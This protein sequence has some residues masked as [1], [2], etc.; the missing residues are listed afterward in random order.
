M[1]ESERERERKGCR[2][3]GALVVNRNSLAVAT[4]RSVCVYVCVHLERPSG[5][6]PPESVLRS[7]SKESSYL[8]LVDLCITQL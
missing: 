3:E 4:S 8:R 2:V 5:A 7:S 6:L 1:C